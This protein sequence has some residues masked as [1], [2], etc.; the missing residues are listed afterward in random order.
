MLKFLIVY[1]HVASSDYDLQQ[2]GVM[3]YALLSGDG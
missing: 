3:F 2:D 1:K